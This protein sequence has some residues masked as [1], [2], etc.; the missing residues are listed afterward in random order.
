MSQ[1]WARLNARAGQHSLA[2][3]IST[4]VQ[5]RFPGSTMCCNLV[6][7]HQNVYLA[8]IAGARQIC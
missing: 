6:F 4:F 2:G 5:G 3:T 8:K 1:K 7:E